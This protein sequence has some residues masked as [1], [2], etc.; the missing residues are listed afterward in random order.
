MKVGGEGFITQWALVWFPVTMFCSHVWYNI[1]FVMSTIVR[2]PTVIRKI[3]Q[4]NDSQMQLL[5]FICFAS[6]FTSL[7]CLLCTWEIN[8]SLSAFT[9]PHTHWNSFILLGSCL[10]S[11]LGVSSNLGIGVSFEKWNT[12]PNK[13]TSCSTFIMN[14]PKSCLIWTLLV[15]LPNVD[16]LI[17][18]NK[19]KRKENYS[20]KSLNIVWWRFIK[21]HS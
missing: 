11:F 19:K 5:R 9:T 2:V 18:F 3:Q 7:L 21:W 13:S 1:V 6:D 20:S 8:S 16:A 15:L 14:L 12:F 17:S 10:V 4:V